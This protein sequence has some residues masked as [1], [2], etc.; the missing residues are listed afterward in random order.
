[1]K[2]ILLLVLV[3]AITSCKE[4]KKE[5][6]ESEAPSQETTT[7]KVLILDGQNNHYVW[8]KTTM[9]MKDY[10]EQTGLFTV[11]IHRMDSLWLGRKYNQS[12][13]EP[14]TSFIETYPLEDQSC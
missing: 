11:D 9:M 12:R 3:C 13:P 6:A 7:L 10:L 5:T 4:M 8:P 2:R 14:Y 1:M